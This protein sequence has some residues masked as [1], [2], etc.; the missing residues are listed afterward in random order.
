M[1]DVKVP[2][3]CVAARDFIKRLPGQ[4]FS[5]A[6]VVENRFWEPIARGD[7]SKRSSAQKTT[8]SEGSLYYFSN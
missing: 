4:D 2:S 7:M 8:R 6:F 1:L 5:L 3:F